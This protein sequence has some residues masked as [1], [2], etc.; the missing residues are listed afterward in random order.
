MA[1]EGS[2]GQA[3]YGKGIRGP[4][5]WVKGELPFVSPCWVLC[6]APMGSESPWVAPSPFWNATAAID[7]AASICDLASRS[8][9]LAKAIGSHL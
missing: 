1:S 5:V 7:A 3:Q 4:K 8:R 2:D 9:P 6:T